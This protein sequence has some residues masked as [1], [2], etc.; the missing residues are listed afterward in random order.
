MSNELYLEYME[1]STAT[2]S[3]FSRKIREILA[4]PVSDVEKVCA[5]HDITHPYFMANDPDDG[6][7][8]NELDIVFELATDEHNESHQ[9]TIE[10][11]KKILEN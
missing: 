5:L 3:A 1:L 10:R 9:E 6:L 11:V 8:E 7:T 4:L 2:E